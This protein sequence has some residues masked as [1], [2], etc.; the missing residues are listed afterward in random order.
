MADVLAVTATL[1]IQSTFT[2]ELDKLT[3]SAPLSLTDAHAFTDGAGA[4][5]AQVRWSDTR[6]LGTGASEDLDLASALTD[7]FGRTVTFTKVKGFYFKFN[8]DDGL[9]KIGGAAAT[10]FVNWVGDATDIVQLVPGG[11]FMIIAP[12]ANGYAVGAGASD[13]LKVLNSGV[14]TQTYDVIIWGEG[15]TA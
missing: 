4:S 6:S 15:T 7:A 11:A 12:D 10:Q 3:V 13:L 1:K 2:N 14:D 9:L 5:K 8:G